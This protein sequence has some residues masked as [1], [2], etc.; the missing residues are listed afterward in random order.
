[1]GVFLTMITL[2]LA[3]CNSDDSVLVIDQHNEL[4]ELKDKIVEL[5]ETV[6]EQQ[7]IINDHNKEFSYL[8]S[9]TERE[10]KA[11]DRFYEEKDVQQLATLSPET[12]V[13]LYF[14][15][16]VIDDVEA[17]YSLTYNDGT[18]TDLSTFKQKY[19]TEG[20]HKQNLETTLDF[21]YYNTIKVREESQTENE[22]AVEIGVNFGLFHPTAILGLKKDDG[23]WKMDL[24]HLLE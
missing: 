19:Y 20:L 18:L 17:L 6:K 9:L 24:L 23:I 2:L 1:M 21:R 3:G 11:Y 4:I 7:K 12:I 14:H 13:L 22:V 5:E 8:M 10:L 15:S 16:V